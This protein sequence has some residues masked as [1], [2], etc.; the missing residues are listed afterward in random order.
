MS[1]LFG[2]LKKLFDAKL[3]SAAESL[4]GKDVTKE[5]SD[6]KSELTGVAG[7]LKDGALEM[8]DSAMEFKDEVFTEA[9]NLRDDVQGGIGKV[10]DA[11]ED[12]GESLRGS[13]AGSGGDSK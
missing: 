3:P 5:F 2:D 8:K 11:V 1:D 6:L 13:S 7:E 9:T 12:V 4:L 10:T